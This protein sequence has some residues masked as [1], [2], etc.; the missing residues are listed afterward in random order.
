LS[1]VIHVDFKKV[2]GPESEMVKQIKDVIYSFVGQVTV[3]SAFGVL[4]I[5]KCDLD[6]ELL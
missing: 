6:K 5:V 4:E 3:A 1:E 2:S